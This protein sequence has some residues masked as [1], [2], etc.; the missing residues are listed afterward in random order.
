MVPTRDQIEH[1]AYDRWLRRDRAHGYD[2][3][4]W[5]AAENELTFVLNYR[6][7]IEYRLDSQQPVIIGELAAQRCRF[8]ERTARH[9]SFSAPRPVVQGVGDTSLLSAEICDECQADCRDP[10]ADDCQRL[11]DAL[12]TVAGAF[13]LVPLQTS[14]IA[15]Y[16]S[17]IAGALLVMPE[18]ELANFTDT[19]EWVN[20]PDHDYDGSLF[21][22]T[23]CH[24]YSAPFFGDQS[25]TSIARRIDDEAPHP[26]M[27]YFVAWGG[28]VIQVPV[29]LGSRDQD[30]DGKAVR[31]PERSLAAGHGPHFREAC[32]TRLRVSDR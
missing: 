27:L 7:I 9:A 28:N 8:C 21:G 4:D 20:N 22:G 32:S 17:L 16:K 1:A 2:R 10:L 30:L 26:Y 14:S 3:A 23:Y 13:P 19:V 31:I 12:K 29:P 25:W 11:W 24:V 18:I 5:L 6:T 15:A